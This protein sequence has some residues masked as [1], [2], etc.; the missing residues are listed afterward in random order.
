MTSTTIG[1]VPSRPT[2]P[3]PRKNAIENEVL[4]VIIFIITELMFFTALISAY[5][6]IKAATGNTWVPPANVRL[7]IETTALNTLVLLAS[8]VLCL[9][10]GRAYDQ[11][12]AHGRAEKLFATATLLGLVF[13]S[14]QGYEWSKLLSLGMTI[15]SGVFAA[16]FY[17]LIGAHALHVI[18]AVLAMFW[19]YSKLKRKQMPAAGFKAMRIFWYFVVGIWP[20]LYVLVYF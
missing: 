20:F 14:V 13:V 7:P 4:G 16:T 15:G 1:F 17:L 11:F 10:A 12:K 9:Q 5:L 19:V 3:A 18:A 8:G 2:A 6:V